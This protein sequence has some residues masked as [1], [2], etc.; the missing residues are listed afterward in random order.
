MK[1]IE[2][3]KII[4]G[5]KI[6][7]NGTVIGKRGRPIGAKQLGYKDEPDN[8]YMGCD[9]DLGEYGQVHS[10]HRAIALVFIPNPN[11]LPQV[12]HKN[13]IKYDNIKSEG[14]Y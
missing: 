12:N 9:I 14:E 4:N 6:Y 2:D 7:R 13:G 10:I 8:G 11:N 5:Y 3:Y 1:I